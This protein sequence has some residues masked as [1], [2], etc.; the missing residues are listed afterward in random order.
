MKKRLSFFRP[1]RCGFSLVEVLAAMAVL[2]LI[3]LMVARIFADSTAAFEA[4]SRRIDNNLVARSCL[5]FMGRELQQA[6]ADSR[7]RIKVEQGAGPSWDGVLSDAVNFV[8]MCGQANSSTTR[9]EMQIRYDVVQDTNGIL[10][11]RHV[12]IS[13]VSAANFL[14]Y[15]NAASSSISDW[16]SNMASAGNSDDLAGNIVGFRIRMFARTQAGALGT[17]QPGYDSQT[18]GPPL[19]ADMFLSVL[20]PADAER[21][22]NMSSG[23]D[24]YVAKKARRYFYRVFFQNQTGGQP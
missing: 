18:H 13:T 14:A 23:R 15:R 12:S 16:W 24:A 6:V 22:A 4:G 19:Y 5:E 10:R 9:D 17:Y 8:S 11:L 3:V 1:A 20:G 21:A 7:V 2:S